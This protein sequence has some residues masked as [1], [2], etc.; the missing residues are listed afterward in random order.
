[1]DN[2]IFLIEISAVLIVLVIAN[3]F[4]FGT[5]QQKQSE[6]HRRNN[7][8]FL[9]S[10]LK[11]LADI[12]FEVFVGKTRPNSVLDHFVLFYTDP[13]GK[14]QK[15]EIKLGLM[16]DGTPDGK[17]FWNKPFDALDDEATQDELMRYRHG[18]TRKQKSVPSFQPRANEFDEMTHELSD[19]L[20]LLNKEK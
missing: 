11:K 2:L 9:N 6:Q 1:M 3:L 15:R 13:Q 14:L 5:I 4:E 12:D 19:A 20:A 16:S 8:E 18:P 7:A 17:L 10:E